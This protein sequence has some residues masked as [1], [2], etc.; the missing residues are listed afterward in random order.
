MDKEKMFKKNN[1]SRQ[2]L[3]WIL[4]FA[5]LFTSVLPA[6]AIAAEADGIEGLVTVEVDNDAID[7][8]DETR[9]ADVD[10]IDDHD[11]SI[12]DDVE[13]DALFMDGMDEY[14]VLAVEAGV[15]SPFATSS[16][17]VIDTPFDVYT[18]DPGQSKPWT[19][20]VHNLAV[21][22][23]MDIVYL[24]DRTGTMGAQTQATADA[25]AQFTADLMDAG[26]QDIHFGVA[27][28]GGTSGFNPNLFSINLPLGQHSVAQVQQTIRTLP[29]ITGAGTTEDVIWAYMRAIHETTWREG[30]QRLVVVVTDANT[31]IRANQSVGGHP[32]TLAGAAE[33][34]AQHGITPVLMGAQINVGARLSNLAGALGLPT[35][36]PRFNTAPQLVT[37][38]NQAVIPPV[39]SLNDYEVEARVESITFASDGED[40]SD[41]TIKDVDGV[42]MEVGDSQSL[43]VAGGES[44]AF[45][46]T[47][48]AAEVP[49]RFNDTI[50]AE[51]GFYV[52][53][54]RVESVT[55]SLELRVNTYNA[56]HQFVSADLE[57][58]LPDEV[59][60]LLPEDQLDLPPGTMVTPS[61]DFPTTVRVG[62]LGRWTFAGWY[63][64]SATIVRDVGDVVFVGTWHYEADLVCTL[65]DVRLDEVDLTPRTVAAGEEIVIDNALDF[66]RIGRDPQFP[67]DGFYVLTADIDLSELADLPAADIPTTGIGAAAQ[68]NNR[69]W[70]EARGWLGIGPTIGLPLPASNPNV[71]TGVL[72][73]GGH[74]IRGLWMNRTSAA[75]QMGVSQGLFRILRGAEIRDLTLELDGRGIVGVGERRGALAGNAFDGTVINNVHIIGNGATIGAQSGVWN[76]HGGLVGELRNSVVLHSSVSDVEVVGFSY[77]GGLTGVTHNSGQMAHRMFTR[78]E[79]T[80]VNEV[81]ISARGSYAGGVGGALYDAT[82]INNTHVY[83]ASVHAALSYAGGFGGVIGYG[84]H[85]MNSSVSNQVVRANL[86]YAGGFVGALY[87]LR[88]E[89]SVAIL[90]GVSVGDHDERAEVSARNFAGGLAGIIYDHSVVGFSNAYANVEVQWAYVGG[91]SGRLDRGTISNAYVHGTL[92]V[93]GTLNQTGALGGVGGFVGNIATINSVHAI[94]NSYAN[95]NFNL[96][97]HYSMT[98]VG[99]FIGRQG[100]AGFRVDG[101]YS[102]FDVDTAGINLASGPA[103][104]GGLINNADFISGRSTSEMQQQN[105]FTGWDFSYIWTMDS[106][107][108][109]PIFR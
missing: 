99:G 31:F 87:G 22:P 29:A 101:Y 90:C 92:T 24:I 23:R 68:N 16:G 78:I 48:V 66:A 58:A 10:P 39:E 25:L 9:V 61:D 5:M 54:V 71:F 85:V 75:A 77:I 88:R 97:A 55:Q 100:S 44:E 64:E 106:A 21:N 103:D 42:I 70:H 51:I 93:T 83:G 34:T 91:F 89:N 81:V 95:V 65:L 7:V 56:I 67:L 69:A 49:E 1:F 105:T 102:F 11:S 50:I 109:Y 84:T 108:G 86:E 17:P 6:G 46:F 28:F 36:I 53:G 20:D 52:D 33:I 13:S 96:P 80:T 98:R 73:G 18:L 3:S 15:I 41:I 27:R 8:V 19:V 72:D 59:L 30:A 45:D 60:D 32:A 37:Q 2:A 40:S 74:T 79:E 82:T 12:N 26:A 63:Q 107:H 43:L 62:M 14:G 57:R 38:L 35:P 47:A 76:Y 104:Q 4:A 94:H